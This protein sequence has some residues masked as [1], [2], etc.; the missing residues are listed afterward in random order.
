M[1]RVYR[2]NLLHLLIGLMLMCSTASMASGDDTIVQMP[3]SKGTVYQLLEIIEKKTEKMFVYDS[4]IINN[5][6]KA[7]IKKGHYTLRQAVCLIVGNNNLEVRIIGNHILVTLPPENIHQVVQLPAKQ[8][9]S[10]FTIFGSLIDKSTRKALGAGSVRVEGTS[11]GSVT[12]GNGEFRLIL[13][14]SLRS[15]Y[16]VFSHLGYGTQVM[17]AGLLSNCHFIVGLQERVIPLQEVVLRLT[18]PLHLLREMQRNKQ[19][20]YF[21][22]PVY[23]TNFYREGIEYDNNFVKLNEGVFKVYKSSALTSEPDEVE[24]LK[25]RTIYRQ[26][27]KDTI[28]AK[29]K[30][31]IDASLMLDIVK[32][33]PDFMNPDFSDYNFISTGIT[34]VDDRMANIVYFEQKS[35]V[36]QPLYCGELFIDSENF[37]LLGANFEM[38]PKYVELATDIFVEKKRRGMKVTPHKIAY[39]I[40][41]KWWNGRYYMNYVRGDLY[42]KI[43]NSKR[44]F[45]S[46]SRLHTWFEMATCKIDTLQ[47]TR[48]TK[49]EKLPRRTVFEEIK[50][51]YDESFWGNFNVVPLESKLTESI[52]KIKLKIEETL[53]N[54]QSN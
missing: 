12:N 26:N 14:D 21:R 43:K 27:E 37:A 9:D 36:D 6:Q 47:V 53:G 22:N 44:F 11:I 16:V 40:S 8:H 20:N 46:S 42:F 28:M 41:Y 35:G 18:N 25:M 24:L 50:F 1:A 15:S 23:A 33:M 5:G 7:S 38:N 45:S 49:K 4:N 17:P 13:P 32:N 30:A 31:G 52:E 19:D 2:F 39:S 10:H 54:A 34:T 51:P 48:F 3:K 29:I